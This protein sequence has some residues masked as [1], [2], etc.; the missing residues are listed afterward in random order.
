MEENSAKKSKLLFDVIEESE[1]F[2]YDPIELVYRS[3]VNVPFVIL[4]D[5]RADRELEAKFLQEAEQQGL[6]CLKG[7]RSVGGMRASLYNATTVEDTQRLASFMRQFL[8][9]NRLRN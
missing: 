1:G 3:R 6:L 4:K 8:E 2:Y 5:G 9:N 7:H